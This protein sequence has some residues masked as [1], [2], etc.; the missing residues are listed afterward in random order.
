M[1]IIISQV[2]LQQE[3]CHYFHWKHVDTSLNG[4]RKEG[5]DGKKSRCKTSRKSLQL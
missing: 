1:H 5:K 4:G 3:K 2:A